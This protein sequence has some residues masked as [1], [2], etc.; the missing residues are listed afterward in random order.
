MSGYRTAH[1]PI[2]KNAPKIAIVGRPNVGKSTLFNRLVGKRLAIVDDT[3]GVTRDRREGDARL[4]GLNFI[5]IDTPG[6]EEAPE[7]AL[8]GRMRQQTEKAIEDAAASI[9]VIDARVGV[10][11]LDQRFAQMLRESGKPVIIATQMLDSMRESPRPTRASRRRISIAR[12]W[13]DCCGSASPT[14]A[15]VM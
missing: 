2:S 5:A 1:A 3:P 8:E 13:Q 11:P 10:T 4:G 12:H 7:A 14:A 15:T 9:F 6:L